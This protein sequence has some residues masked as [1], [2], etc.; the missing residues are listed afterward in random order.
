MFILLASRKIQKKNM[1]YY[2]IPLSWL[3]INAGKDVEKMEPHISQVG[4]KYGTD[5]LENSLA[6]LAKC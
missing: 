4:L 5:T 1:R 3:I 6:V 2:F